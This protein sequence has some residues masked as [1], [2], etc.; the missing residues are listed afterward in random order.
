[1]PATGPSQNYPWLAL[2]G[3]VQVPANHAAASQSFGALHLGRKAP[4]SRENSA[5]GVELYEP[6]IDAAVG[7]RHT[8]TLLQ[9]GVVLSNILAPVRLRR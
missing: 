1:M 8:V 4:D 7:Q 9:R 6:R 3:S 2:A 5:E